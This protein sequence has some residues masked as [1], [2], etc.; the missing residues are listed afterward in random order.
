MILRRTYLLF[1]L[2]L[3]GMN[4]ASCQKQTPTVFSNKTNV[5]FDAALAR[6]YA[7]TALKEYMYVK[8]SNELARFDISKA[9]ISVIP[10]QEDN[11][12][13][14]IIVFFPD[15]NDSEYNFDKKR[16]YANVILSM[17]NEG[18]MFVQSRGLVMD[19]IKNYLLQ[20]ETIGLGPG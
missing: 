1:W 5:K 2:L 4:I 18:Y 13:A 12:K 11:E 7:V 6:D 3:L 20:I 17:S 19:S 14:L 16:P 15:K 10:P 9:Y 8:S